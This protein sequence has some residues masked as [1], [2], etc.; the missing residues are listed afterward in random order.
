[1]LSRLTQ[2]ALVLHPSPS[3]SIQLRPSQL[4]PPPNPYVDNYIPSFYLST[5]YL[6][7]G[8]IGT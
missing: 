3:F 6:S 1:M 8:T 5:I 7:V 4:D 2:S